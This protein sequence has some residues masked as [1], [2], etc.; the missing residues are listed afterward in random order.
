MKHKEN[1]MRV[2]YIYDYKFSVVPS[3]FGPTIKESKVPV[4]CLVKIED[5]I[6]VSYCREDESFNKQRALEI[7]IGRANVCYDGDHSTCFDHGIPNRKITNMKAEQ[8]LLVDEIDFYLERM[9]TP[10]L[11]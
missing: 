6:G 5:R 1:I 2:R 3:Q 8:V 7:A 11:S 4:A 9:N 10:V